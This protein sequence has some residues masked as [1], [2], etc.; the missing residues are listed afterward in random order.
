MNFTIALKRAEAG[1]N[2]VL[3]VALTCV[4]AALAFLSYQRA[5]EK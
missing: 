4:F 3:F 5:G 2:P 1:E